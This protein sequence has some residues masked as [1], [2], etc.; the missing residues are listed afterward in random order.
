MLAK[1]YRKIEGS[2]DSEALS[3]GD[4]VGVVALGAAAVSGHLV[5]VADSIQI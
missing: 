1:H 3:F 4:P 5:F 2:S